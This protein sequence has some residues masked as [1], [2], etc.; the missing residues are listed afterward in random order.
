MGWFRQKRQDDDSPESA[1][2]Q[3]DLFLPGAVADESLSEGRGFVLLGGAPASG[4]DVPTVSV[5]EEGDS[6]ITVGGRRL[7]ANVPDMLPKDAQEVRRL[8]FEHYW[9][10]GALRSNY[11]A[12]ISNPGSMLDVGCGSG[13]WAN[14]V[15]LQF[16]HA[17]V[18]ALDVVTPPSLEQR[19]PENYVFVQGDVLRG[20]PF[21]DGSFD[22]VH[23]RLLFTAIPASAWPGVARELVRVTRLG[24]WVEMVEGGL[25]VG[26][27]AALD[28]LC[29]WVSETSLRR[30]IDLRMGARVGEFLQAAH[31]DAI[32]SHG[33]G[34]P[35]GRYGG[36]FG[37][38]GAAD[39]LAMLEGLRPLVTVENVASANQYDLMLARAHDELEETQRC[40]RPFYLA[41]GQ[42]QR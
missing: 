25:P 23:M 19:P 7:L 32:V 20:M 40:V 42:R 3:R 17:N 24:G 11:A 38:M 5:N 30:G 41:F 26:G 36:R 31:I 16:P 35:A 12:P 8:D 33:F 14:E 15:A 10:R 37:Q 29:Q 21:A 28:Q 1:G 2:E 27:G 6:Y 13:R 22:F 9:L 18:I 34:L 39:T 4:G